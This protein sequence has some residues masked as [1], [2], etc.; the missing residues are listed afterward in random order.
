MTARQTRLL[1]EWLRSKGM[2]EE[3]IVECF[4]FINQEKEKGL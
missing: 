1:I 2:T 3:Q 4:E